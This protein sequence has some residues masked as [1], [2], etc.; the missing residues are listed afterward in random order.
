MALSRTLA[1][2]AMGS[3]LVVAGCGGSESGGGGGDVF[4]TVG[5]SYATAS[6]EAL[7]L[8]DE[9]D[10]MVTN[11]PILTPPPGTATYRGAADFEY[12]TSTGVELAVGNLR[13]AV[14]FDGGDISG[15]ISN[16]LTENG[17][18]MAGDLPIS[19][20]AL[21]GGGGSTPVEF[22]ADFSGVLTGGGDTLSVTDGV[23]DGEFGGTNGSHVYGFLDATTSHNGTGGVMTGAFGAERQ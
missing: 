13:L 3:A 19:A 22:D 12:D 18:R 8:I 20:G 11:D 21:S 6:A 5:K 1:A 14:D 16:V 9:A 4:T 2:A 17:T 10:D 15:N 23:I 7:A